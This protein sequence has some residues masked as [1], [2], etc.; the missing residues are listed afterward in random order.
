[1]LDAL[2]GGYRSVLALDP[3]EIAALPALVLRHAAVSFAHW[4]GRWRQGLSPVDDPRERAR[5]LARLAEW[6]TDEG[7]RLVTV[8]AGADKP[9][10]T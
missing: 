9:K 4:T 6:L 10:P 2:C 3:I 5:R 1:M 8:A 7:P